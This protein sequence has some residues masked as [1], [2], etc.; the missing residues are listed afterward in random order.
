MCV[1]LYINIFS[2]KFL[3]IL[4]HNMFFPA[5]HQLTIANRYFLRI[6][7][8]EVLKG[9]VQRYTVKLKLEVGLLVPGPM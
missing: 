7:K 2:I 9:H 4:L 3:N 6:E 1:S 8:I 5:S